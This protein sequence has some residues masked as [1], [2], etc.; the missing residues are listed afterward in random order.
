MVHREQI[1]QVLV[2]V[3]LVLRHQRLEQLGDVVHEPAR[4]VDADRL[5]LLILRDV[6]D[7]QRRANFS[8]GTLGTRSVRVANAL[9]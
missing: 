2:G 9:R 8:L 5:V 4:A 1:A 6:T 7:D 3:E